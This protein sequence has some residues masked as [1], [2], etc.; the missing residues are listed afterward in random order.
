[1]ISIIVSEGKTME[2]ILRDETP[3][4]PAKTVSNLVPEN[5]FLLN[6]NGTLFG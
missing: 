3:L 2:K 1:M 6:Q 4:G 5:K